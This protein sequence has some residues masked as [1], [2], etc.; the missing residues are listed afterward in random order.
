MHA[1][2][3]NRFRSTAPLC[4]RTSMQ[5]A[6]SM[7]NE[8]AGFRIDFV[9]QVIKGW[10]SGTDRQVKCGRKESLMIAHASARKEPF[11]YGLIA[12]DWFDWDFFGFVRNVEWNN[13]NGYL[14][15]VIV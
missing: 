11:I 6:L 13:Q 12:I 15:D 10:K 7:S 4:E 2:M 14:C 9:K 5:A 8:S 1:K 3:K